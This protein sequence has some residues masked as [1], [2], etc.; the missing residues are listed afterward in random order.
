MDIR[1]G[2]TIKP[3]EYGD[4]KVFDKANIDMYVWAD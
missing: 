3:Y 1:E 4:V 2:R